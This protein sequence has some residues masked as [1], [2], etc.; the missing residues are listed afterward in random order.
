V[1]KQKQTAENKNRKKILSCLIHVHV[2]NYIIILHARN[3][4]DIWYIN[5]WHINF[6][7]SSKYSE[8]KLAR[9]FSPSERLSH[10]QI[11]RYFSG[12]SVK[13]QKERNTVKPSGKRLK[14]DEAVDDEDLQ[15]TISAIV[16]LDYTSCQKLL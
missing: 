15:S 9:C 14:L 4:C 16:A 2:I 6:N 10:Q 11:R 8:M 7:L 1:K 3:Y 5:N 13:K 12:F